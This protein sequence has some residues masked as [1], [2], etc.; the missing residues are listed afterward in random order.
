[1]KDCNRGGYL[2]KWKVRDP[3]KHMEQLGLSLCLLSVGFGGGLCMG[4]A[5]SSSGPMLN[6]PAQHGMSCTGCTR[7]GCWGRQN[8]IFLGRLR[9]KRSPC[10]NL[11][12]APG[13]QGSY[14]RLCSH[15]PAAQGHP[16]PPRG[17]LLALPH[18]QEHEVEAGS[19]SCWTTETTC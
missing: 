11:P 16:T 2:G 7:T 4:L 3:Q 15:P 10:S 13:A 17:G 12:S 9:W 6:I 19:Q 5:N 8:C 1:M 18:L 14:H